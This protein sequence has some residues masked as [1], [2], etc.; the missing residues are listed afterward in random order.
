M[1][2]LKGYLARLRNHVGDRRAAPRYLTHLEK[3]L[4]VYVSRIEASVTRAGE[5]RRPPLIVGYTRD[6]SETGLG[7]IVP[8]IRT[9]GLDLSIEGRRLRLLLGLPPEPVEMEVE[10]VRYVKLVRKED[11]LDTGYLVGVHIVEMSAENRR[12]YV[13]FLKTLQSVAPDEI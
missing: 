12:R 8:Q 11:E 5:A 3:S 10:P 7:V 4:V 9:G 1:D 6:V 13:G 2:R